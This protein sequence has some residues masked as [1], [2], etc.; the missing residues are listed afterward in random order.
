MHASVG[1][2]AS[3]KLDTNDRP[4]DAADTPAQ[5]MGMQ[6]YCAVCGGLDKASVSA[7]VIRLAD[8]AQPENNAPTSSTP[9]DQALH[10]A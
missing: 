7:L 8:L 2:E 3:A 1:T 10:T 4:P 9:N 5:P 6:V